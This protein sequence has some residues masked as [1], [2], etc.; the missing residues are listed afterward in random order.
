[1]DTVYQFSP[2]VPSGVTVTGGSQTKV[3]TLSSD[4]PASV[5]FL[6]N[7]SNNVPIYIGFTPIDATTGN[8]AENKGITIF[9]ETVFSF[10]STAVPYG[11]TVWAT[12]EQGKTA[13][14]GIQ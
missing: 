5:L 6:T 7:N 13:D 4:L 1:M 14:L 12:C 10:T 11:C 3:I 9:P 2:R 8:A